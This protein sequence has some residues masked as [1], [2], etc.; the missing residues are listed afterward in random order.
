MELKKKQQRGI[1]AGL[2]GDCPNLSPPEGE[3]EEFLEFKASL[4]Y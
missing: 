1:P 4:G 2:E 3:A